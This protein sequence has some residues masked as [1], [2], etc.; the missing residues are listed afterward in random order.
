Q[1]RLEDPRLARELAHGGVARVE[2]RV[3]TRPGG[4]G[5]VG[6]VVGPDPAPEVAIAGGCTEVLEP[7]MLV[8]WSALNRQL[9]TDPAMLLGH[10]HRS[11]SAQCRERSGDAADAGSHDEQFGF[12]GLV[13]HSIVLPFDAD[14]APRR[15]PTDLPF[16][17]MQAMIFRR[18]AV[19][20]ESSI[21][22]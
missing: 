1:H 4:E 22:R 5:V 2:R 7:G 13:V 11:A 9:P 6:G 3:A 12:L 21:S 8:R 18:V 17:G 10:H 20:G 19:S 16:S 15:G 14:A